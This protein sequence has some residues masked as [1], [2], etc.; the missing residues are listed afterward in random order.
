MSIY[1]DADSERLARLRA[2]NKF[3]Y[4]RAMKAFAGDRRYFVKGRWEIQIPQAGKLTKFSGKPEKTEILFD[5]EDSLSAVEDVCAFWQWIEKRSEAKPVL[6]EACFDRIIQARKEGRPL[7]VFVP[8]G[9]RPDYRETLWDG[10]FPES[11]AEKAVLSVLDEVRKEAEGRR[12]IVQVLFMPADLYATEIN[13]FAPETMQAYFRALK[14]EVARAGKGPSSPR[15]W[16]WSAIRGRNREAYAELAETYTE[17]KIR[18]IIPA[19]MVQAS[20]A[21]A[22]RFNP[23]YGSVAQKEAAFRYLRERLCEAEIIEKELQP[24]KFSLVDPFKDSRV[25]GP[26]PRVYVIPE[27]LKFPWLK[28]C[29]LR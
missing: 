15:V 23:G 20:L 6:P 8:W 17:S 1:I 25:D 16:P 2:Q 18:S 27:N 24:I 13:N 28:P 5:S 19:G 22:A 7:N 3:A 21:S 10:A 11:S 9:V 29:S 12:I 26:L 14:N 4:D